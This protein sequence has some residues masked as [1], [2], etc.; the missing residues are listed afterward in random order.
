VTTICSKLVTFYV[1]MLQHDLHV[2]GIHAK[3]YIYMYIYIY[4]YIYTRMHIYMYKHIHRKHVNGRAYLDYASKRHFALTHHFSSN[5]SR[6]GHSGS[7]QQLVHHLVPCLQ[8]HERGYQSRLRRL[9][10]SL[11]V[12]ASSLTASDH[13][14]WDVLRSSL[15]KHCR[16]RMTRLRLLGNFRFRVAGNVNFSRANSRPEVGKRDEIYHSVFG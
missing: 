10:S 12:T 15:M 7:S 14:S 4:I 6:H 3:A 1:D 9:A 13:F 5:S 16:L 2:H 8:H 11:Q